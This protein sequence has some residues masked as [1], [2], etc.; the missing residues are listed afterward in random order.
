MTPQTNLL[1]I[2]SLKTIDN[3]LGFGLRNRGIVLWLI[4]SLIYLQQVFFYLETSIQ[5]NGNS[6]LVEDGLLALMQWWWDLRC[7]KCLFR[8][9]DRLGNRRSSTR[10]PICLILF[11][12]IWKIITSSSLKWKPSE[13]LL[14]SSHEVKIEDEAK[15]RPAFSPVLSLHPSIVIVNTNNKIKGKFD[16]ISLCSSAE[17][18]RA[19]FTHSHHPLL[20]PRLG[21]HFLFSSFF[22]STDILP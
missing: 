1:Q 2:L 6:Y 7:T 3:Q 15:P 5:S 22:F 4:L 18:S 9:V 13:N 21:L 16:D 20:L 8:P 14:R 19:P 17:L 12:I 10:S 11:I